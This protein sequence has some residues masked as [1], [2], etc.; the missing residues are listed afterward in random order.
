V[1]LYDAVRDLPV[2]IEGY[3]LEGLDLQA[4]VDRPSVHEDPHRVGRLQRTLHREH[5]L[6]HR[7]LGQFGV[8]LRRAQPGQVHGDHAPLRRHR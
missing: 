3:A 2:E 1:S 4:R 6:L 5:Q 7:E 8:Q